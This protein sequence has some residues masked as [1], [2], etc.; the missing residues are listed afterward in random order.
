VRESGGQRLQGEKEEVEHHER[1]DEA[2][3]R[4]LPLQQPPCDRTPQR[5]LTRTAG[6]RAT[7]LAVRA[8]A[9][10]VAT[11]RIVAVPTDL[12]TD[13]GEAGIPGRH[14]SS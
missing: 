14:G 3:R 5:A 12:P 11:A 2:R 1:A 7:R 9:C 4:Q 13:A 6:S 8:A 10:A